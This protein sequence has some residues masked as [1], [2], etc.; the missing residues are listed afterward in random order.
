[1]A[2]ISEAN[3]DTHTQEVYAR[4]ERAFGY[5]PN[6][7]RLFSHRPEIIDL[8]SALQSGLRANMEA[9]LFELTTLAAALA[10]ES[11]Y[12]SL[13]H[14][15]KLRTEFNDAELST[16]AQG[17][18]EEVVTSKEAIAMR[19]AALVARDANQVNNEIIEQLRAH[20]YE[21]DE[22]FDIAGIAAGRAFFSKFVE[23]LGA[24]PDHAYASLPRSL[25]QHLVVGRPIENMGNSSATNPLQSR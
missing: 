8:W 7:A 18:F 6:Y 3:I 13:A 19:Y 20:G 22:I 23:G 16:L 24:A 9:R 5:L 4:Q 14:A 11:S 1:M 21:D 25:R 12:C 15:T 2:F 17:K 10:L